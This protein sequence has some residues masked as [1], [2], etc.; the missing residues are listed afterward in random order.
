MIEVNLVPDVKQELI[1]AQ[2]IR[3][4]VV[5]GSIF[6]GLTSISI[7]ALLLV[8]VFAFQ[9]VRT[10]LAD[11]AIKKGSQQLAGVKDLSKTIT[12]QNQLTKLSTLNGGKQITSR[13]FDTLAK[14]A[15]PAPNDIQISSLTIDTAT[16][17]VKIEGQAANSYAALEVFKKTITSAFVKYSVTEGS[18]T[19]SKDPTPLASEISTSGTSYGEDSSGDKVLRFVVSFNC[20]PELFASSSRNVSVSVEGITNA[21][22][23]YLGLPKSLF[24]VR[25][26]D[27]EGGN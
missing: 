15:P 16:G 25:A 20:A 6:I 11:D 14:I 19:V 23:S 4:R 7:V 12:I 13:I 2:R 9:T 10:K 27:I 18:K 26:K 1:E 21:T 8:Y 5:I 22:D 24:T 17:L 3:S